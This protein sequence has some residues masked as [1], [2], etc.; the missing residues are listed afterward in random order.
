MLEIGGFS[1]S[2]LYATDKNAVVEAVSE[3]AVAQWKRLERR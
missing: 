3:A 2:D 1:F